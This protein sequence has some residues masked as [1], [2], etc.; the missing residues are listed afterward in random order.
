MALPLLPAIRLAWR[1]EETTFDALPVVQQAAEVL[2]PNA[3][4]TGLWPQVA[5]LRFV[6]VRGWFDLPDPAKADRQLQA[7]LVMY[8]AVMERERDADRLWRWSQRLHEI[9]IEYLRGGQTKSALKVLGEAADL[10]L[11]LREEPDD[12]RACVAGALNRRLEELDHDERYA[13]LYEWTMPT[14]ARRTVRVLSSTTSVEA[15]PV[16]F[17]RALG[18]R[19]ARRRFPWPRSP[20]CAACSAPAGR[21]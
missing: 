14:E 20:A 11:P 17:A 5:T 12:G 10:D 18:E 21:W 1:D 16:V 7:V 15:P 2:S 19:R 9:A 13:L 4:Q 6:A 8:R 3:E